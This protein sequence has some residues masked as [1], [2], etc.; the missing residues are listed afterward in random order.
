[1]FN[2]KII[3]KSDIIIQILMVFRE[4][5]TAA[6]DILKQ[7]GDE[8]NEGENNWIALF[9]KGMLNILSLTRS[10]IMLKSLINNWMGMLL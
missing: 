10:K 9:S 6:D 3:H 5:L 8:I 1:M 4:A 2:F 7:E